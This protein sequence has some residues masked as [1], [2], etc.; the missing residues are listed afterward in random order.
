MRPSHTLPIAVVLALVAP[1]CLF[2][3]TPAADGPA[4]FK[5]VGCTDCHGPLG[6]GSPVGP[7]LRGLARHWTAE[8]LSGFLADPDA[9]LEREPR[10][11]ELSY[12]FRNRMPS[13]AHLTGSQRKTLARHLV[14]SD[15]EE[16]P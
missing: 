1:A 5:Q 8:S 14:E 10:L 4:L 7:P 12:R 2:Y 3:V 13:F 9:V 16:R 11:A 6:M 15:A